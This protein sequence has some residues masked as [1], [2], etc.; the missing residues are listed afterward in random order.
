MMPKMIRHCA[1]S[2][3]GEKLLGN[4]ITRLGFSARAHERILKV[5]STIADLDDGSNI[6]PRQLRLSSPAVSLFPKAAVA[7]LPRMASNVCER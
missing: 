7:Y 4:A 6:E 2:T 3:E 1:V 5:A